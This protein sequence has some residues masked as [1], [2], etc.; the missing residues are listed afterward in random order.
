MDTKPSQKSVLWLPEVTH[1]EKYVHLT[2]K[3]S[4]WRWAVSNA[5]RNGWFRSMRWFSSGCDPIDA[6]DFPL[7]GPEKRTFWRILRL[8]AWLGV[9]KRLKRFKTFFKKLETYPFLMSQ[10]FY[11]FQQKQLSSTR[12]VFN[13]RKNGN[14]KSMLNGSAVFLSIQLQMLIR[15]RKADLSSSFLR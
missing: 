2:K 12:S 4:G 15:K 5:G 9:H 8:L 10:D 3:T 7:V 11:F 6:P 13:T 1:N 14:E